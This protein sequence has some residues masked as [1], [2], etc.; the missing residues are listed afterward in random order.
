[1]ST[2]A[3]TAREAAYQRDYAA[4]QVEDKR[5]RPLVIIAESPRAAAA[6]KFRELAD[7][8]ESG[9]LHAARVSWRD[10]RDYVETVERDETSCRLLRYEVF[11]GG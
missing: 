10:G 9:E 11:T 3:H 5:E 4:V 8:L 6:A 1:M 2:A 7:R